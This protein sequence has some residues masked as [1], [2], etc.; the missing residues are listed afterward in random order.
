MARRTRRVEVALHREARRTILHAA[1]DVFARRG[2]EQS[3]VD[4]IAN[5]ADV[6]P[7]TVLR[8]FGDK[9]HLYEHAVRLAG[10]RFLH[11][12]R[13][14]LES[15]HRTL[16]ETLAEW[17]WTLEQDDVLWA[18]TSAAIRGDGNPAVLAASQSLD[19]RLAGFWERRLGSGRDVPQAGPMRCGELA[20]L[21]VDAA[22]A[23]AA[24]RRNRSVAEV[25]SALMARF[26]ATLVCL[27]AGHDAER[28]NGWPVE[29]A[30]RGK[31][32]RRLSAGNHN[33]TRSFSARELDVLFE[34]EKGISNKE[35]ARALNVTEATVKFHLRNIFAKLSVSRRTEALRVAR[36]LGVI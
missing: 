11:A 21:I 31:R 3:S 19:R 22:W 8:H 20:C 1:L 29:T 6:E 14:H 18:L 5:R 36:E 12:M 23:F 2:Y 34:V 9:T 33:G 35:I 24:A 25:A 27:G 26:A 10:D 17:V 16:G 15:D 4:D 32:Q 28:Q 30:P 13:G 7:R